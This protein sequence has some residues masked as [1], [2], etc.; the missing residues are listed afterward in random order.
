MFV[1]A[2]RQ[3]WLEMKVAQIKLK[4]LNRG[5]SPANTSSFELLIFDSFLF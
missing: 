4:T 3:S 1:V 5:L 2:T